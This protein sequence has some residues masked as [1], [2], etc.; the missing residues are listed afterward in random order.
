MRL[1]TERVGWPDAARWRRLNAATVV[2]WRSPSTVQLELG[3]SR[4][5]IDNVGPE[6]MSA[7]LPRPDPH[8]DEATDGCPPLAGSEH[9]SDSRA[10]PLRG[11]AAAL[12]QV[13][14]R[15]GFLT[16][17]SPRRMPPGSLPAYLSADLAALI[18]RR[19]DDAFDVMS[20]RRQSAVA[21]YGTSRIA[22][23]VAATLASAGVGSVQLMD[24]GS[25]SAADSCPGGLSP[26]DEGSRFTRAGAEAV[27]RY[28]PDVDTS[29]IVS[30]RLADLVILTDP[31]P[32]EPSVRDSLHLDCQPHLSATVEASR[33]VI[34]PLVLPG[35]TSCLRCAD[36][37]RSERDPCWPALAVQLASRPSH[38]TPSDGA[39]CVATAGV[40]AGQALTYL[41]GER[42]ETFGG[43]MEW[44]L[45]DWR[46]RRRTWPP[47]H[48]CDCGA[49]TRITGRGRMGS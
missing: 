22:T 49:A 26:S 45:P 31:Q 24:A 5:M 32:V 28:A 35:T 8:A 37:H 23:A 39:L 20:R 16:R 27:R 30:G 1:E 17:R 19:G 10:A 14:H 29:A 12:A 7:L 47:H 15:A 36:L 34:G 4:V 44:Q 13:L 46:L 48:D 6:Q 43:T 21:L 25:I 38:R 41:D 9:G 18:G 11:S 3:G 42:P 2:L 33:A 40:A